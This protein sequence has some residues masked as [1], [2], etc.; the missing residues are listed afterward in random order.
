MPLPSC[1]PVAQ[2]RDAGSLRILSPFLAA[3]V[4]SGCLAV[5]VA[6]EVSRAAICAPV[7]DWPETTTVGSCDGPQRVTLAVAGDVLLHTT[8]Q[9]RGYAEGFGAIWGQA[10]PVLSTADIAVVNLEG[11][12]APGIDLALRQRPDPGPVFD[13][14]V[15]TEY[16]RFNYHPRLIDDLRAAGVDLVTTAN[17]HALDRGGRGA[18]ATLAEL[19]ARGMAQTGLIARGAPR[20]FA[21]RLPTPLGALSFIGCSFS[22]NGIPDPHRQVLM[23]FSDRAELL[24]LVRSEAADPEVAGVVVLPHWG[25]EY[26]RT[27]DL[28][29]RRLAADLAEAGAMAVIGTHPHVVQPWEVLAPAGAPPVPVIYSTGNFVSGQGG[30]AVQTGIIAWLELCRPGVGEA[31]SVA[32]AGAAGPGLAG[33]GAVRS[34]TGG[35]TLAVGRAGWIPLYMTRTVD[36]PILL[37]PPP[38]AERSLEAA[39]ALVAEVVPGRDLS[40]RVVCRVPAG[41]SMPP[42]GG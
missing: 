32:S 27:P 13:G 28:V 17:N 15:Y 24:A 41:R 39:R 5:P 7:F 20:D 11:A 4:L 22:T 18:E 6:E 36:G 29:N 12:V 35:A 23:C 1:R 9:Q 38:G 26:T 16:P 19:A 42:S 10:I 31:G 30:L 8:L 33:T 34:G 37:L 3:A 2:R 25:T 40:A 14:Q 21:T